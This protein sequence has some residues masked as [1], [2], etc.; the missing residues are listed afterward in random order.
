[1][2]SPT[3]VN[4]VNNMSRIII[5][6]IMLCGGIPKKKYPNILHLSFV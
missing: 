6:V 3:Y 2:C 1:M 5:Q 4:I